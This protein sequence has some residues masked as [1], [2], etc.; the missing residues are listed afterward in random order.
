MNKL[1]INRLPLSQ[2]GPS[3]QP[4]IAILQL[5]LHQRPFIQ[6]RILLDRRFRNA[7]DNFVGTVPKGVRLLT[8]C[9]GINPIA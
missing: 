2:N 6:K 3:H 1:H 8:S 5:L 9:M 4:L 7:I